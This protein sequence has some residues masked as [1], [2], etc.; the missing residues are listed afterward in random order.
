MSHNPQW[1]SFQ[2]P[3]TM[4]SET[5]ILDYKTMNLQNNSNPSTNYHRSSSGY[6]NFQTPPPSQQNSMKDISNNVYSSNTASN[7]TTTN[8]SNYNVYPSGNNSRF[9][10]IGTFT[11]AEANEI[12]NGD[13]TSSSPLNNSFNNSTATN[14]SNSSYNDSTLSNQ[15]TRETGIIEKLLVSI[16]PILFYLDI[17]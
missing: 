11:G 6:N 10:P 16:S 1:K 14:N 3:P 13:N 4:N 2:P 9:P 7:Y 8:I 17:L 5:S 15:G 12:F